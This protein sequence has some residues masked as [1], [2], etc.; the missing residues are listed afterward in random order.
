M[1]LC[2]RHAYGCCNPLAQWPRRCFDTWR[3]PIFRVTGRVGTPLSEVLDLLHG[4]GLEAGQ[5]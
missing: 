1:P 2:H 4:H 3:M 5:V